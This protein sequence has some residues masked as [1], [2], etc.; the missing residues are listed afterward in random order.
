MSQKLQHHI[1]EPALIENPF[2][3]FSLQVYGRDTVKNACLTLQN[4][5]CADVNILLFLCWR[6]SLGLPN[7]TADQIEEM[8][9]VIADINRDVIA[10]LRTVR[11]A[12][13]GMDTP[14]APEVRKKV[15]EAELSA[16]QM[17]QAALF[18]AFPHPSLQS[19]KQDETAL[20]ALVLY[21]RT[22][23]TD[24]PALDEAR[25]ILSSLIEGITSADTA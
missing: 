6:N 12:L 23:G 3:A 25:P 22:L 9:S 24:G 17:A 16:E 13:P 21:F 4:R 5:F 11:T 2:W 18:Q 10:P 1:S 8:T 15:L 20:P 14:G 19:E 7:P